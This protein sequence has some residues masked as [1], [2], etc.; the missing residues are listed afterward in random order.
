VGGDVVHD[1]CAC[2]GEVAT[3]EDVVGSGEVGE[4]H[5]WVVGV[6]VVG[7]GVRGAFAL[8]ACTAGALGRRRLGAAESAAALARGDSRGLV[9]RG[10]RQLGVFVA[11]EACGGSGWFVLDF[12]RFDRAGV[13]RQLVR[14]GEDGLASSTRRGRVRYC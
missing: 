13:H 2:A 12:S 9:W 4:R 10:L 11:G 1:G 8:L 14:V 6:A 5:A 3:C 7:C